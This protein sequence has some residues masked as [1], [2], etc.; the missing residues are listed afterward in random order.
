MLK[1]FWNNVFGI[2]T[3]SVTYDASQHPSGVITIS[4]VNNDIALP[5]VLPFVVVVNDSGTYPE[6]AIVPPVIRW[7]SQNSL[8]TYDGADILGIRMLHTPTIPVGGVYVYMGIHL[9]PSFSSQVT[10]YYPTSSF[11]DTLY[12]A[13]V[14]FLA[15]KFSV[16][17]TLLQS[18]NVRCASWYGGIQS[19]MTPELEKKFANT[20]CTISMPD[21]YGATGIQTVEIHLDVPYMYLKT[22]HGGTYDVEIPVDMNLAKEYLN[23]NIVA[24]EGVVFYPPTLITFTLYS[25]VGVF[26]IF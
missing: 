12:T 18:V 21:L 1:D 14:D 15:N 20:T 4:G 22:I 10:V 23:H 8:G 24:V 19:G 26:R 7:Y 16:P 25:P 3:P 6:I 13:L 11:S 2:S 9:P 17:S 5:V